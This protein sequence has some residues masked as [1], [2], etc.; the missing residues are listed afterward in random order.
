M[1]ISA[2][3]FSDWITSIHVVTVLVAFGSLIAYPLLL[4][5]SEHAGLANPAALHAA[6]LRSGRMVVNPALVVLLLSGIYLA[7][8]LHQW[9]QFY[10]QWGVAMIVILAGIEGAVILKAEKAL[11]SGEIH[12]EAGG[13][14]VRRVVQASW[15]SAA[16]VI[17]TIFLMVLQA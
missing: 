5:W 7:S 12:G 9:K 10:T 13:H 1:L 3:S 15:A 2:A 11:A 16:I 17:V 4:L 14:Q 8:D 6:R